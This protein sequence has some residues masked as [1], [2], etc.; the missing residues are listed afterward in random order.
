MEQK[1]RAARHH[2][3]P[4]PLSFAIHAAPPVNEAG[5]AH[6]EARWPTKSVA[7]VPE[8]AV[9]EA[10]SIIGDGGAVAV[11]LAREAAHYFASDLAPAAQVDR[12]L[13]G[14]SDLE[15]HAA[16]H[17]DDRLQHTSLRAELAA[18]F[19][20]LR[21]A[22][23]SSPHA[24][25]ILRRRVVLLHEGHVL[26]DAGLILDHAGG[27]ARSGVGPRVPTIYLPLD[28]LTSA[29]RAGEPARNDVRFLLEHADFHLR[30]DPD[31]VVIAGHPYSSHD[32]HAAI[33]RLWHEHRVALI[34]RW[35]QDKGRL[36]AD[37][38][39]YFATVLYLL[40]AINLAVAGDTP[41]LLQKLETTGDELYPFIPTM[42]ETF[43]HA[44]EPADE[45][46]R[47]KLTLIAAHQSVGSLLAAYDVHLDDD[48]R[49]LVDGP[50]ASVL[51]LRPTL[52]EAEHARLAQELSGFDA[53]F[54]LDEASTLACLG[55]DP[56]TADLRRAAGFLFALPAA[57][58]QIAPVAENFLLSAEETRLLALLARPP[59]S[60]GS[61]A[62]GH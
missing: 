45:N 19:A 46:A 14:L 21:S 41:L 33:S 23:Q 42:Y 37:S 7:V 5:V 29:A 30:N 20:L 55:D 40:G 44:L 6:P 10:L 61:A 1:Q 17:L 47:F 31:A 24:E 52:N 22:A 39:A 8:E 38:A 27:Q 54:A 26:F 57:E 50:A 35:S 25:S 49:T 36:S 32:E 48:V 58:R 9:H 18:A 53:A 56:R 15:P 2:V 34:A 43:R 59:A 4:D 62:P 11:D 28:L 12:L 13:A 3:V 60:A 16:Q 51:A